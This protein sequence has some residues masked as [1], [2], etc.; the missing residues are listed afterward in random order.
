MIPGNTFNPI[1]LCFEYVG[2]SP[3]SNERKYKP[4]E[5][6]N[7]ANEK[8]I[9]CAMYRFLSGQYICA[10]F[11]FPPTPLI[12]ANTYT[13]Q[14]TCLTISV[15]VRLQKNDEKRDESGCSTQSNHRKWMCIQADIYLNIITNLPCFSL[16]WDSWLATSS[17]AV[18]W[19]ARREDYFAWTTHYK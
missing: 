13:T 16:S 12:C 3:S 15:S 17:S 11:H 5:R 1:K 19:D 10:L 6:M 9:L 18:K 7:G 8:K 14:Y 4:T 2:N